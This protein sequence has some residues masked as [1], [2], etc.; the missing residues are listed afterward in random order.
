MKQNQNIKSLVEW[1]KDP[2]NKTV[3]RFIFLFVLGLLMLS[4]GKLLTS[5]SGG[6]N[7]ISAKNINT[8]IE[9]DVIITEVPYETKLEKQ[10]ADLLRQASGVGDVEVMITL[11]DET[12]VEPAFNTVSTE[13]KSEEKD[14]E[15][16]VRTVTEKQTN[17]QAV[18][19][20]RSGEEEAMILKKTAPRIKGILIVA[21]GASSSKT[22][23]KII[24]STATLLD[25]PIY[26]ISVLAK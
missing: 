8:P 13:K 23:A 10:L 17:K 22:R 16:G 11:E 21:D 24:K 1:I 19:L 15:G 5:N 7:N 26:K 3:S 6:Q 12:L 4:L 18:L 20:R 9:Q 25:I 14:N 2:K